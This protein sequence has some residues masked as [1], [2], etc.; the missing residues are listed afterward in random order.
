MGGVIVV[1]MVAALLRR[2]WRW[3]WWAIFGLG[4]FTIVLASGIVVRST[5]LGLGVIAAVIGARKMF[6]SLASIF[7]ARDMRWDQI[8]ELVTHTDP[9]DAVHSYWREHHGTDLHVGINKDGWVTAPG[10]LA[11]VVLGRPGSGKTASVLVP[12]VLLASRAVI[13]VT[14]KGPDIYGPTAQTRARLGTLWHYNP[15]GSDGVLPGCIPLR[16]SPLVGAQNWDQAM[17][18]GHSLAEALE[19]A[20]ESS[21]TNKFFQQ[22]AH[23]IVSV[24]LHGAA[25]AGKDMEFVLDAMYGM[26]SAVQE[27]EQI[28]F[29]SDSQNAKRFFTS[30]VSADERTKRNIETTAKLCFKAYSTDKAL[31]SSLC[32][33]FDPAAFARSSDTIYITAPANQ[34]ELVGPLIVTLLTQ[35]RDARYE[36]ELAEAGQHPPMYWALDELSSM[37]RIKRFPQLVSQSGSTGLFITACLQDLS[38]AERIWGSEGRNL[39]SFMTAVIFPGIG[40]KETLETI[41]AYGEKVWITKVTQSWSTSASTSESW[42]TGDQRVNYSSTS[43]TNSTQGKSETVHLIQRMTTGDVRGARAGIGAEHISGDNRAVLIGSDHPIAVETMPYYA[44]SPFREALIDNAVWA[45]SQGYHTLPTPRLN[46]DDL[47]QPWRE[48]Y[49]SVLELCT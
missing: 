31:A 18:T 37:A 28:I 41:S 22:T 4:L 23:E 43:A 46:T 3:P 21:A 6:P 27:L 14:T 40:N 10:R 19:G 13:A 24:V 29:S 36:L 39:P 30:L 26:K 17:L 8:N 2:W 11:M 1:L 25:I 48:K 49:E 9:W 42:A 35:I 32:P 5:A 44:T 15:T 33:N 34:Q 7:S 47:S 16:W 38:Q 20:G 12:Q 45:A